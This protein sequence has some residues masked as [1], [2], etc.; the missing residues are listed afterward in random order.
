MARVDENLL[1]VAE[2]LLDAK[3]VGPAGLRRAI[4][5]AYYAVFRRLAS[6]CADSFAG[7][8]S[9]E[10]ESVLRSLNHRDVRK[11]LNSPE[12]KSLLRNEVG[13]LFEAL[14]S[15]R[16]WADYSALIHVDVGE[17]SKR[18][19]LTRVEAA[20]FIRSARDIIAT[21]DALNST[22]RRKLAI[23]LSF[24]KR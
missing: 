7:R 16:E 5:T 11:A 17:A 23:L 3:G 4:S 24:S 10:Y 21:I 22:D 13:E 15:A 19:A 8:P 18:I 20:E 1:A 9:K 12:A 14:L 6:L 2:V